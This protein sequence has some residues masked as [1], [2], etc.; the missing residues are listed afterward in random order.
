MPAYNL[1]L[2]DLLE[3]LLPGS[4]A[5]L[6]SAQPKKTGASWPQAQLTGLA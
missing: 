6:A 1:S 3:R 4:L 2:N 5:H